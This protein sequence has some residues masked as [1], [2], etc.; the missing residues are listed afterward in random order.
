MAFV[1]VIAIAAAIGFLSLRPDRGEEKPFR[2][3]DKVAHAIAYAALAGAA[4]RAL[5][6]SGA[7]A[8][9]AAALAFVAAAAYGGALEWI[10]PRFGRTQSLLD[11]AANALGAA[12]G[13]LA[14]QAV[15]SRAARTPASL[16]NID[17]HR[18]ASVLALALLAAT[19]C[20]TT[21]P[22]SG[23]VAPVPDFNRL[24]PERLLE[25]GRFRKA[26]RADLLPRFYEVAAANARP[27][28]GP[29]Y[30]WLRSRIEPDRAARRAELEA[31][32]RIAPLSFAAP[33]LDLGDL[34]FEDGDLAAAE[35]HWR[36]AL[37]ILPPVRRDARLSWL[38]DSGV[39]TPSAEQLAEAEALL[40]DGFVADAWRRHGDAAAAERTLLR[41]QALGLDDAIAHRFEGLLRLDQSDWIAASRAFERALLRAPGTLVPREA[42]V[43]ATLPRLAAYLASGDQAS[44]LETLLLASERY[45]DLVRP[46]LRRALGRA[47]A[48]WGR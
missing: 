24:A 13:A 5:G 3:A 48:P 25:Q 16:I 15:A 27:E 29:L 47:L 33:R 2:H 46:R 44:A 23:T 39:A 20:A 38:P 40:P 41:A 32:A 14:W 8:G 7:G 34:A 45:P 26:G 11:A 17:Q 19:G 37:G 22:A 31:V 4:A 10:Q 6:R 12:L 42:Y 18:A 21:R 1:L 43:R 30:F 35:R 9:R 36:L 28:A